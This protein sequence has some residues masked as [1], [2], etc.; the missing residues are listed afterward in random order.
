MLRDLFRKSGRPLEREL[1]LVPV[2]PIREHR[3]EDGTMLA[4][5]S[6]SRAAQLEA[7]EDALGERLGR[8]WVDYVHGFAESWDVVRRAYLERPYSPDH[9]D[10]A[11]KT[12]LHTRTTLHKTV[13][14]AFKDER[15]RELALLGT[16]LDGHDPR[17]VPSWMGMWAYVEHVVTGPPVPGLNRTRPRQSHPHRFVLSVPP[18]RPLAR[19]PESTR[20]TPAPQ[21]DSSRPTRAPISRIARYS[22]RPRLSSCGRRIGDRRHC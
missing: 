12:L 14:K 3:F 10:K 6:G 18:S 7:V 1:E 5:P 22:K 4:M 9:I 2:E 19:F 11:T 15:L 8:Q 16:R 21:S 20:P 13:T 17:N